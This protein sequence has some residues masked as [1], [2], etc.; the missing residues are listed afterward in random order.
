VEQVTVAT[1]AANPGLESHVITA[2]TTAVSVLL[3]TI[4]VVI[5]AANK[6]RTLVTA[7]EIVATAV[8]TVFANLAGKTQP[9][10]LKIALEP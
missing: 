3:A 7:L 8:L 9:T 1:D 10:V 6:E 5:F 4:F 2:P